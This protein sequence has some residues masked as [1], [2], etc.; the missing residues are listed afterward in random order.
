VPY[1]EAWRLGEPPS[2]ANTPKVVARIGQ[3][4]VEPSRAIDLR[5]S[6]LTLNL[7]GANQ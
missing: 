3:D 1:V 2:A 7:N 5:P 4:L 6:P